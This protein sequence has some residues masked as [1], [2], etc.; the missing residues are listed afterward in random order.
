M[1]TEADLDKL[2]D[3][4]VARYPG[5]MTPEQFRIATLESADDDDEGRVYPPSVS[6][7]NQPLIQ[8]SL[9]IGMWMDK[10]LDHYD[11]KSGRPQMHQP[12]HYRITDA[13]RAWLKERAAPSAGRSDEP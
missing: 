10:L 9:L 12:M 3:D 13:G 2:H 8:Q 1:R 11:D 4:V 5:G 7:A 6:C